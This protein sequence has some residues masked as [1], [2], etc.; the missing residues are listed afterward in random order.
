MNSED[1]LTREIAGRVR[2]ARERTEPKLTQDEMG[3]RLGLSRVAY[4]HYE[5]GLTPFTIPHLFQ[6][7]QILG[8][9]VEYFL[10]LTTDLHLDEQLLVGAY[11][12]L[13]GS[14]HQARVLVAFL[15]L[16]R[17]W[18]E[19]PPT[20]L[21]GAK[22]LPVI[23]AQQT[24]DGNLQLIRQGLMDV[25]PPPDL[26]DHEPVDGQS[27]SGIEWKLVNSLRRMSPEELKNF[28]SEL[29]ARVSRRSAAQA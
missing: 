19:A 17:L 10:G 8:Q 14:V 24:P 5:R 28:E 4:G 7:A 13:N 11:R 2:A 3:E 15:E 16:C 29:Q 21:D 18:D 23:V 27:L 26:S 20:A 22:L 1:Q 12:R 25:L 9:P 6:I